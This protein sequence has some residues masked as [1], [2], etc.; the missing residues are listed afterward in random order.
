MQRRVYVLLALVVAL[1][2]PAPLAL[3]SGPNV[4]VSA[5][6]TT[7][8]YRPQVVFEYTTPVQNT[9]PVHVSLHKAASL[10]EVPVTVTGAGT[11]TIMLQVNGTLAYGSHY[12]ASVSL[13]DGTFDTVTW[14][15][16]AKPAHPTLKVKVITALAPDAV[17][18]IVRR[19][20]R[21]NLL[22][23]PHTGDLVDISA[24]TGRALTSTD[25]KG[26][27]AALVVTD[28]DVTGQLAAAGAL[29]TF[30]AN[31]HGV[32]LGGQTHWTSG[33]P[34]TSLSAIGSS[35][36]GWATNWSPL[37]Y[38]D[39]PTIIGGAL[40]PSSVQ[41]HFLTKYLTSLTVL[42][43]GSGREYTRPLW[44]ETVLAKLQPQPG[45]GYSY[46][47]SLLAIHW[48]TGDQRGRVVDLGFNPWS[49]DVVSGGG[50]FDPTVSPQAGPLVTRALWWAM[51]RIPPTHT[52]F[53]SKPP[54]PSPFA[55]VSF[56]MAAI[57][58]DPASAFTI[59]KYQYKVGTG[60]WKW[61]SGGTSFALYHLTPG[62]TY[63]VR[64]R[65]VDSGGNKDLKPAVYTFR[66]SPSAWG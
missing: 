62:K 65:A 63:T 57:D 60:S 21:A 48:D 2:A 66:L 37:E 6:T 42:G 20:D 35:T 11:T 23:V 58:A 10:V 64:A 16:R 12:V 39:P 26:Y 51:N 30:A 3:A 15:T 13:G 22:A 29:A 34:W 53:T 40:R 59:M 45:A 8:R 18:D 55:T 56:S 43:A 7:D 32:V 33:G 52:H 19:L 28:Q 31:G 36:G 27:Q 14:L 50:G 4:L 61:A 25:L 47:Q 49:N 17:D 9:D 1:M 41:P 24:A 54:S 38:A 46:G 5:T 44:N